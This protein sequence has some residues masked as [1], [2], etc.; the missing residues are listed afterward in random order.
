M[1]E[2]SKERRERAG[3]D[4]R[5]QQEAEAQSVRE[6][7]ARLRALRLARDAEAGNQT[8]KSTARSAAKSTVKSA[9]T[10]GKP[11]AAKKK[12]RNSGQKGA[13][14]SEWLAAQQKD[15]RHN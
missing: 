15:G 2:N 10:A 8:A 3:A 5:S 7:T 1:A 14:L 6:K 13:S 12:S 11:A 9:A 4:T